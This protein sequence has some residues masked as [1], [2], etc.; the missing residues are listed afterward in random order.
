[1][2]M[3]PLLLYSSLMLAAA[4]GSVL[5]L[6]GIAMLPGFLPDAQAADATATAKH[7]AGA[8]APRRACASCGIVE[9]VQV[10]A[11]GTGQA[12]GTPAGRRAPS[13]ATI[14]RVR[15]DDGATRVFRSSKSIPLKA[16][17]RVQ[18]VDGG[19]VLAT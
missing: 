4:S 10:G 15:F 3:R 7:A 8:R 1:M 2:K 12:S 19:L 17:D 5:D 6:V 9:S 11:G 16:G 13:T 18:F 14:V